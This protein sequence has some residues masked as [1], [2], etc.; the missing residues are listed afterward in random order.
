MDFAEWLD[1]ELEIHEDGDR[2]EKIEDAQRGKGGP[3]KEFE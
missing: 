3:K 1:Y 2:F